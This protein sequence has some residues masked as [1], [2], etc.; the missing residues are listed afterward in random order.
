MRGDGVGKLQLREHLGLID[1]LAVVKED[2]D[3]VLLRVDGDDRAD[4]AVEHARAGRAVGALP[5]QIVV[6]ADLHDA[7]ALAEARAAAELFAPAGLRRVQR[8]LQGAVQ[9]G[10]P[11]LALAGG[12]DDLNFPGGDMHILRQTARAELTDGLHE[13]RGR[14]AAQEEAVAVLCGQNG[15]LAAVDGV[16]VHD[17]EAL[18]GLPEN[19][20]QADGRDD[21]AADEVGKQVA[22]ADARQ[23]VRV[24]DEHKAGLLR[25]RLEQTVHEQHV[26]HGHLVHDDGVAFQRLVLIAGEEHLAV[27]GRDLRLEQAMD[28]RGVAAGQL[29][30]TLGG[31]PGRRGQQRFAAKLGKQGEDAGQ[32]RRLAGAGA[33]RQ[34]HDAALG[35][36]ADGIALAF[37]IGDARN[38]LDALQ[39]ALRI[40][41]RRGRVLGH[42]TDAG[43]NGRLRLVIFRQ[44]NGCDPGNG[45]VLHAA[46]LRQTVDGRDHGLRLEAQQLGRCRNEL[47]LREKG[48]PV[49]EIMAQLKDNARFDAAGVVAVKAE[50]QRKLIGCA[51]ACAELRLCQQIGVLLHALE[52]LR[53]VDAV[54]P[55]GDLR[56]DA[57]A[58]KKLDEPPHG[59]LLPERGADLQRLFARDAVDLRQPLWRGLENFQTV[60][61]EGSDDLFGRFR[62]D[63]PHGAG[64]EIGTYFCRGVRQQP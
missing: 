16:G 3:L 11:R 59:D 51:E 10:R 12:A 54:Q 18:P 34:D 27:F 49:C 7:V 32:H 48:M 33:A 58:R 40:G 52:R 47:V 36:H 41:Q 44:V 9:I 13:L 61:A 43:G 24:A 8:R 1:D 23:L 38:G 14:A 53:T 30:Q 20:R 46:Q 62:P 6:I 4:V 25:Q 64:G 39:H 26:D 55:H 37:G 5:R 45:A 29:G 17:D 22:R 28:G 2:V 50:L 21:A 19:F 56:R 42:G 35:C 60:R 15:Q 57:V 63:A 31:A